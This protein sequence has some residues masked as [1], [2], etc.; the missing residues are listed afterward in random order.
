VG[1][2][3][4]LRIRPAKT[5]RTDGLWAKGRRRCS[6]CPDTGA[7]LRKVATEIRNI[8]LNLDR[9]GTD[10]R[11]KPALLERIGTRADGLRPE[12]GGKAATEKCFQIYATGAV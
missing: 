10:V 4:L 5:A 3:S 6:E 7:V 12:I 8:G 11:L 1:R 2:K 9:A